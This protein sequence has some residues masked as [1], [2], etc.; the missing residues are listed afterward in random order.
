[1]SGILNEI[2]LSEALEPIMDYALLAASHVHFDQLS[3][4]PQL[5]KR[6]FDSLQRVPPAR[7]EI[8]GPAGSGKSSTLSRLIRDLTSLDGS[9]YEFLILDVGDPSVLTS[10][11][12]FAKYVIDT[13]AGQA[14]RFAGPVQ[15][16]IERSSAD[17]V[18]LEPVKRSHHSQVRAGVPGVVEAEY[19]FD[20]GE[21]FLK[22]KW[23]EQGN[24]AKTDLKA[25]IETLKRDKR[26]PV[27]VID[28]TEKYA[29]TETGD[30]NEQAL[31][32]LAKHAIPLLGGL[33]IDLLVA[34]HPA[35]ASS[36][37][38]QLTQ[39]KWLKQSAIPI[40][41][42]D[43][44]SPPPVAAIIDKH[45]RARGIDSGWADVFQPTVI[46]QLQST[47][48]AAKRSLRRVL[49]LAQGA[50]ERAH[51]NKAKI[52]EPYHLY[53]AQMDAQKRADP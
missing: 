5:E 3:E 26:R 10:D 18:T 49:A 53:A 11:Q 12:V 23:G 17:E 27:V 20:L 42:M 2:S 36:K 4:G 28:D 39:A 16:Q 47:Y 6:L 41:A 21:R 8:C 46:H 34:T 40:L 37:A 7:W 51:A 45:L 31:T 15:E 29:L 9:V 13:I 22:L 48:L 50:V 52:V 32:G 24:R 44:K 30:V 43:D 35:F 1:M 14:N 33:N 38:M 19:A 25:I